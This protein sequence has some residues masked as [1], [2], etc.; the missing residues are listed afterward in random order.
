MATIK[1]SAENLTL[2]ADGAN[3]DVIIQSNA[4]TKVTVDGATGNVGIGDTNPD[5]AKLSITGVQ[6]GDAGLKV[7]QAQD[8]IGINLD[9]NGDS[10][11]LYIDSESTSYDT[12]ESYGKYGCRFEVDISGGRAGY[13]LNNIN[14]SGSNPVVKIKSGGASNSQSALYVQQLGSGLAADFVGDKIRVADGILF[15]TDTAAANA[16]DDYE[17]GTWTMVMTGSSSGSGNVGTGHYTKIGRMVHCM[18]MIDNATTPTFSGNMQVSLPFT[19]SSGNGNRNEGGGDIYFYPLSKWTTG[20]DFNGVTFQVYGN[21][22][23]TGYFQL[24]RTNTNRQ[25]AVTSSQGSN[26]AQSGF[27]ARFSIT[28]TAS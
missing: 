17:E 15:G 11:A 7:V 12:V 27:Y 8:N 21:S 20:S 13:F 3:N 1:S 6:S 5:E 9:Q 26:S 19:G 23:T 22:P 10:R 28:Y 14:E 24:K 18:F 25:S 2:N 4:S 16:L